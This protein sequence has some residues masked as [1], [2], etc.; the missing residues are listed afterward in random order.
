[1]EKIF[2][3]LIK[4]APIINEMFEGNAAI[5]ICDKKECLYAL[6][7]NNLKSPLKTGEAIDN[8]FAERNG[9]NDSIY[10]KKKTI[11]QTFNKE[12]HGIDVRATAIPLNNEIGEV[13]GYIGINTNT[14]EFAK[15]IATTKELKNSLQETNISISDIADSAVKLSEKLN[16]MVRNTK[17]TKRLI[18]ESSEA[19]KLIEGI[20]KQSNLLGLNAAIESSRAGE[21]GKGFSV[22]AG[23]M[24]K[25]AFNS[26]NSSKN[27]SD[28][29]AKMSSSMETM[30]EAINELG[31]ISTNQAAS[32][33]ELSA[34]VEQ[35]TLNSELLFD[36]M[37]IK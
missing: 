9:I 18:S 34:T 7:G 21:Y 8:E 27:I 19:V 29:L 3:Y 4:V 15:I 37:K 13:V 17:D 30:I 24:R 14:Q 36:H 20:A 32:L 10:R 5:M 33:E 31:Q 25:L 35:I 23:E 28:S 22:V 11:V 1:M 6:D 12:V 2:E 16:F 26:G